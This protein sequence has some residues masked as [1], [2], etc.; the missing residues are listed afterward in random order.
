MITVR[1]AGR[2]STSSLVHTYRRSVSD[3]GALRLMSPDG[4]DRIVVA[5]GI[6]WFMTLFG[7]DSLITS[8]I[9]R[10]R[11]RPSWRSTASRRWRRSRAGQIGRFAGMVRDDEVLVDA[12]ADEAATLDHDRRAG[13]ALT[14][15]PQVDPRR[16]RVDRP[17]RE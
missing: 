15:R 3:L 11:S 2:P 12:V 7:R 9:W 14:R 5:A 17:T 1:S 16:E 6:P 8:Y 10:C 4:S 13:R